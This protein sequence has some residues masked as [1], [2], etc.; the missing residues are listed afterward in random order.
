MNFDTAI[1][2]LNA[3]RAAIEIASHNIANAENEAHKKQTISFNA[4]EGNNLIG[5]GVTIA[6]VSN[7]A[8]EFTVRLL[9][10]KQSSVSYDAEFSS[11]AGFIENYFNDLGNERFMT[12]ISDFFNAFDDLKNGFD[13]TANKSQVITTADTMMSNLNEIKSNISSIR[14]QAELKL[15]SDIKE[16]NSILASISEINSSLQQT[17]DLSLIDQRDYLETKLSEKIGIKV[18][19]TSEGG[20]SI[21]A[22]DQV[23]L[24]G[25]EYFEYSAVKDN[26]TGTEK[27]VLNEMVDITN[28]KSNSGSIGGLIE[29]TKENGVLS[30]ID[31]LLSTFEYTFVN[32]INSIYSSKIS[33]DISGTT[34]DGILD[35]NQ[36]L[37]D[38]PDFKGIQPGEFTISY[39]PD[40]QEPSETLT[41]HLDHTT[42]ISSLQ[43][44][45][46]DFFSASK[47]GV[48]PYVDM[49]GIN[50][51]NFE[52]KGGYLSIDEKDTNFNQIMGLNQF[53]VKDEME[54]SYV[55]KDTL[56]SNPDSLYDLDNEVASNANLEN[57]ESIADLKYQE[58]KF[59]SDVRY[60]DFQH[61]NYSGSDGVY[62]IEPKYFNTVL[63]GDSKTFEDFYQDLVMD[64][65][66]LKNASDNKLEIGEVVLKTIQN[67]YNEM[68]KVD[69]DEEL[70]KLME[71][72]TAYQANAKA[73]QTINEAF[74]YILQI[75]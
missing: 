11:Q 5:G 2:G 8:S 4:I 47:D 56:K 14:E 7:S 38:N 67:E 68:V 55:V 34:F 69:V 74:D 20:Y 26:D 41:V 40:N 66:I 51:L 6:G 58:V 63:N 73:I 9:Q 50:S 71:Y 54:D 39:Y 28:Q 60:E 10:E 31:E 37:L 33:E 48:N 25:T 21:L 15:N 36:P 23:I 1:S 35:H 42:T 53:F 70:A 16:V 27:L 43:G 3:S 64:V 44:Q 46:N 45:I 22:N 18:S 59:V 57:I 65:S 49:D 17:Q 13:S 24:R 30:E 32:E 61:T 19:K 29:F 12:S 72:Q 52:A 62:C 75:L